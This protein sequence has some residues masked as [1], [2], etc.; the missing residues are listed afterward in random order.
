MSKL[1]WVS[2]AGATSGSAM[3]TL[4]TTWRSVVAHWGSPSRN[5]EEKLIQDYYAQLCLD[6]KFIH[7]G[8]NPFGVPKAWPLRFG[9]LVN[10][11][12][13]RMHQ[14]LGHDHL[15]TCYSE[16]QLSVVCAKPPC[17]FP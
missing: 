15:I 5:R 11:A 4:R 12:T 7:F 13:I 6:S 1:P 10:E 8:S 16:Q 3:S 2:T 9:P 14:K 17:P